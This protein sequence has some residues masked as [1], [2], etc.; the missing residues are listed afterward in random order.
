MPELSVKELSL[1]ELKIIAQRIEERLNPKRPGFLETIKTLAFGLM[2]FSPVMQA[3]VVVDQNRAVIDRIKISNKAISEYD[4]RPVTSKLDHNEKNINVLRAYMERCSELNDADACMR[5]AL[6]T[7]MQVPDMVSSHADK[8]RAAGKTPPSP[9]DIKSEAIEIMNHAAELDPDNPLY[10]TLISLA[11]KDSGLED[12]AYNTLFRA[13]EIDKQAA[14][15]AYLWHNG[16][17]PKDLIAMYSALEKSFNPEDNGAFFKEE[18]I[19][20]GEKILLD[21]IHQIISV[22]EYNNE[23][24][25]FNSFNYT[26]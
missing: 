8:M 12:G 9:S 13:Y 22:S 18:E 16:V 24:A 17:K 20:A 5:A 7:Y 2:F 26:S 23:E 10:L 4:M 11:L 19:K 14:V 6:K 1:Q 3:A 15:I 21:K 25:S